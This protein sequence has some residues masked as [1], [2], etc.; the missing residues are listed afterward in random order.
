MAVQGRKRGWIWFFG[1]L[2]VIA[3]LWVV[4]DFVVKHYWNREQ[5]T[6]EQLKHARE[7]WKQKGPADY[8]LQY[9][10]IITGA[11]DE[12]PTTERVSVK[13]RKGEVVVAEPD[14]R[15]IEAKRRYYGMPALFDFIED[16]LAEDRAPDHLRTYVHATFDPVD[17][18]LTHYVRRVT[19]TK[20]Q[21]ELTDIRLRPVAAKAAQTTS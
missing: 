7:L 10:K 8:D 15:P 4:M 14:D 20:Q 19:G 21:I 17:G 13:V 3:V 9:I 2:A 18:H 5:L 6:E 11:G 16:F 12:K 1:V